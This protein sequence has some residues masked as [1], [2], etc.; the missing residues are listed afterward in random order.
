MIATW[1][2][3]RQCRLRE[4]KGLKSYNSGWA[5][6]SSPFGRLFS[7]RMPALRSGIR[8][9]LHAHEP[10]MLTHAGLGRHGA[11]VAPAT[12]EEYRF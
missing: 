4:D 2:V 6:A 7:D 3:Y 10:C 12:T 1:S 11:G 8:R 5:H 9:A